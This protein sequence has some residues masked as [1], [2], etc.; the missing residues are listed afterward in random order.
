MRISAFPQSR[1]L[2]I[3]FSLIALTAPSALACSW[4]YPIWQIRDKSADPFYRFARNGKAGYIDR[5]GKIVVPPTLFLGSNGGY[6]F[7][8]GLLLIGTASGS[9]IDTSGK[10]TLNAGFDRNW[11]FSEGLAAAMRTSE[12]RW[13]FIDRTGK[14]VIEPKFESYPNGYVFSFSDGLAMVEVK[15]KYGFIDKRGE[16]EIPPRF[17]YAQ[18]FQEGVARVIVKGPCIRAG[19]EEPCD[20][21]ETLGKASEQD[22]IP[23]CKWTFI[24]KTGVPVTDAEFENTKDFSEGL[25]AV[26]LS[27]KWGFINKSGTIVIPP[28]YERVSNFSDGLARVGNGWPQKMKWGFIDKTGKIVIAPQFDIADDFGDGLAPVGRYDET[29]HKFVDY[30]YINKAGEKAFKGNFEQASH[31]FRGIAHVKLKES[32][33]KAG[34]FKD[35][36]YAYL[37][38]KGRMIFTYSRG[39]E[40]E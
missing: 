32:G 31:Y 14:F 27:G 22:K 21:G 18:G 3:L 37:D 35:G 23:M 1:V 7:H 28:V 10:I 24:D 6:E 39:L 16:F 19:G 38:T 4:D 36:I 26:Q 9:Y 33:G 17:I 12:N 40:D 20:F 15:E 25:A 2:T 13:G 8:D 29:N 30:Y 11:D 5:N 34:S